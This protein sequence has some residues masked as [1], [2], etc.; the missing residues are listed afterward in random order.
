M[1]DYE[2][3]DVQFIIIDE[4]MFEHA[5]KIRK[6]YRYAYRAQVE[7]ERGLIAF[8]YLLDIHDLARKIDAEAVK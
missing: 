4:F 7:L 8:R 2:Y 3:V 6:D 1:L 5:L